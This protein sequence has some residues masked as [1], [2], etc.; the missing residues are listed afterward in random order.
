M[1]R[2]SVFLLVALA[3][4]W[5]AT[6]CEVC[7][8][9]GSGQPLGILPQVQQHFVGVGYQHSRFAT[10]APSLYQGRPDEHFNDYYT[11]TQLWGR[12]VISQRWQLFGAIP[13][14]HSRHTTASA[15]TT[16]AGVGDVSAVLYRVVAG[17]GN[18]AYQQVLLVGGGLKMP[19]G[20]HDPALA[21]E[22]AGMPGMQP[23]TG[24]WDF[25]ASA[26]YTVRYKNTGANIDAA[27]TLT[28]PNAQ[29]V[30]YGNRLTAS[31][32]FF[33]SFPIAKWQLLPQ[34]GMRV[35]YA[36]HDYDNYSR[37]WLNEQTGGYMGY[38]AVGI[39]AY[40]GKIGCRLVGQ[41]PVAQ[42]YGAGRIEAQGKIESS[43]IFMF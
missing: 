18:A 2:F 39:Q 37:K 9:V 35:E 19:T 12:Y 21:V 38:A 32:L 4:T 36:L 17:K 29:Q 14:Q 5:A 25:M 24:S 33:Y 34:A 16:Q 22:Q 30:K 20:R 6:A 41:L 10:T 8:S 23:G 1:F 40:R 43:V 3:T 26:N 27:Y 28:T 15:S 7:G 13:Y 31:T 11:T 42:Y